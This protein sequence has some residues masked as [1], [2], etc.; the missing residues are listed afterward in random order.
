MTLL[1]DFKDKQILVLGAGITGMSCVRYLSAQGLCFTVNDSR[2]QPFV[3]DYNEQQ[4]YQEFPHASLHLGQWHSELI[5]TADIILISP[6]IDSAINE[7]APYISADCRVMG[8]VELF[9][10]LNNERVNKPDANPIQIL[11]VTGSNGKST[12]VSLL[13]YLAERLG[14]NAQLGGNIGQP[15]LDIFTEEITSENTRLPA[16]LILELSSF[17]LETLSSM[18]AIA[19]SVLNVS[20]DHLDRHQSMENYQ[21]IKQRIYSQSNV[22]VI[23]RDDKATQTVNKSQPVLSFGS[24]APTENQFGVTRV[25]GKATLAFAEQKLITLDELPLAGMHNALNYLAVLALG[26]SAGWSIAEMVKSLAGFTGLPHRCQKI[27]SD[28]G[29]TWINDSKATNVGATIAAING[30]AQTLTS[31]NGVKQKLILIAGG[32]GKG[33][34]FTPLIEPLAAHVNQVITL[35]KDGDKIARLTQNTDKVTSLFTAVQKAK[36]MAKA[37]DIVLLSPACASLDMFKNFGDRGEQFMAAVAK[38]TGVS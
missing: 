19:T 3:E 33:A 23:N 25:N 8:D 12:V 1:A 11:A 16:V 28:D 13:A 20:D 35:G 36:S 14:I 4:F 18:Q 27:V 24:D 21:R 10:L 2:T 31:Q 29:I 26:Y 30:L 22:A 37:G 5:A 15:V 6:G 9:C 32:D 17:Q 7:I 34:D 38:V